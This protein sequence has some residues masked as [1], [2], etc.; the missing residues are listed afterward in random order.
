MHRWVVLLALGACEPSART[1]AG[2]AA[3][4]WEVP[5]APG[6]FPLGAIRGQ[7]GRSQA[8]QPLVD[9]G[10]AASGEPGARTALHLARAW[11]VP[12]E[13]PARA[14]LEGR[15]GDRAAIELVDVDRGSVAWRDT[16]LCAAPVAGVTAAAIVCGDAAGTRAVGLDGTPRWRS[17]SPLVAFTDD[18]VVVRGGDDAIILDAATGDERARVRL[19]AAVSVDA[20]VA[21]CGELGRELFAAGDDGRLVRITDARGGAVIRWAVSLGPVA[22]PPAP[23]ARAPRT[24]PAPTVPTVLTAIDACGREAI[25]VTASGPAGPALIA[26]G[27]AS[28]KITGR[29]DRIAGWWPARD[30]SDRLEIATA[31][32]VARHPADLSG[33]PEPLALPPL[34]ELIASRGDRRLVRATPL[35]A[36]V[37]D[38][39]GVRAYLPF[40]AM[41]AVLGDDALVAT[42][43]AGSP[44]ET[45]H[46]LA[47]PPRWKRN[48]RLPALHRGVPL[49]AELRDLPATLPLDTTGQIALPD[50]GVR[51]VV[52]YALDPAD[53]AAVYAV[54]I[55][56]PGQRAAV[57]RADLAARTW[58]WQRVDGCGPGTPVGLAVARDVVVCGTRDGPGGAALIRATSRDGKVQWDASATGM[59]AV[60]AGGDVVIAEDAGRA[61][62]LDARDGR[63]RGHLASDDGGAPRIAVVALDTATLVITAE[64]GRVVARL[65]VGGL[66]PVWSVAVAGVVRALAPSGEGVLVMLEDGDA[67]RIDAR[68]AAIVAL[69]G[70][71]LAWHA[72][73][74]VV[75]GHTLGG[76]IPG[77]APPVPPPR[78]P[79]AAQLLRRPL[80][81]LR[82]ELNTPPP[83]STPIAPPPPLGDSWQLTLYELTG[84]LRARNDYALAAP[85]SPP[86][87][88]GPPGSPLVVPFGPGLREVVAL[89]PRTGTPLRR[90][91]LPEDAPPGAVFGTVVDGSPVAGVLLAAPLRVVL[92]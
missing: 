76:P 25:L 90:V 86:A 3:P 14:V 77:P 19:P 10:I 11:A 36:V 46:R 83:M 21:S 16:S 78:P 45:A 22:A 72:A 59:D 74:D 2:D 58:R 44:G 32:G 18:R 5:P 39:A 92:F 13:G 84:G 53:G 66:L 69:P 67:Y 28:G 82:A 61:A 52:A 41:G 43:W 64:R 80:Q 29:V 57:A 89:D 88:R 79:T 70:L 63:V 47:L 35:T 37:L 20:I 30:G 6:G 50:T 56:H 60:A 73:G 1:S 15:D 51:G 17:P 33:A 12:G 48:L 55:D 81:I 9:L 31:V 34:G 40:A 8:P 68:T 85:V 87:V 26:I 4:A 65:G 27:R 49:D 62:V 91:R 38:P 24:A 75:T 7:L 23:I 42:R 54:A 71:G